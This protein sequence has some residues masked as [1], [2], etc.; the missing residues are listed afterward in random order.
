MGDRGGVAIV[1]AYATRPG[2][3][4]ARPPRELAGW[5]RVEL[6]VGESRRIRIPITWEALAHWDIGLHDWALEPG[7]LKLAIGLSSRDIRAQETV[8]LSTPAIQLPLT[9]SSTVDEWMR[10]DDMARLIS[11]AAKQEGMTVDMDEDPSSASHVRS[12]P[13]ERLPQMMP[14]VDTRCLMELGREHLVR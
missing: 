1:Q 6:A 9:L 14:H 4:V 3:V 10:L 2:S 12:M 11:D 7:L 13:L 5:A 8:E